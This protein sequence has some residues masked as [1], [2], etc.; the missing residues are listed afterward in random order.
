VF[1]GSFDGR[2]ARDAEQ[3]NTP[4]GNRL[5]SFVVMTEFCFPGKEEPVALGIDCTIWGDRES[6]LP[7]MTKG[8]Q[9]FVVG[10]CRFSVYNHQGGTGLNLECNVHRVTFGALP[11]GS[12]S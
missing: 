6:L 7:H 9:V 2:L 4:N 10:D 8:R 1:I 3:K 5:F 12:A 11:K